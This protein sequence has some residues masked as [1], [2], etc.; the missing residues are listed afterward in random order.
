MWRLLR[1]IVLI[2]RQQ[3][4]SSADITITAESTRTGAPCPLCGRVSRRRHSSYTRLLMDLPA[5]G[6]TVNVQL[7]VRRFRCAYPGCRRCVC[8]QRFPRLLRPHAPRAQRL[9]GLLTRIVVLLGGE[10]GARLAQDLHV[11]VSPDTLLRLLYRM[12]LA[13]AT[14]LRVVRI[15]E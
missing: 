4:F 10:A 5:D 1:R 15:D 3:E 2:I 13:P 11:P 8:A 7:L 9:G 12:E 14:I 6:R